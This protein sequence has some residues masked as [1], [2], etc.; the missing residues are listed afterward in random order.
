MGGGDGDEGRDLVSDTGNSGDSNTDHHSSSGGKR[1]RKPKKSTKMKFSRKVLDEFERSEIF[2][3]IDNVY[4]P[5]QTAPATYPSDFY[6]RAHD[7]ESVVRHRDF[8]S[9]AP[10]SD[11]EMPAK[12][13]HRKPESQSDPGT[14]E[15]STLLMQAL[16]GMDDKHR[17]QREL[18][19]AKLGSE[20][21]ESKRNE[22]RNV[23]KESGKR[24]LR[25]VRHGHENGSL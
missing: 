4:I 8:N 24:F 9:S 20:T 16:Q 12:K 23:Q 14:P 2:Q 21:N 15:V 13:R 6:C 22:R 1:K 18:D 5:Y 3:L 25:G 7:D 19:E 10:I 17:A 11:D